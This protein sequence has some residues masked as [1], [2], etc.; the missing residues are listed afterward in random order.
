MRES[1]CQAAFVLA[2]RLIERRASSCM[3]D[4]NEISELVLVAQRLRKEAQTMREKSDK[5]IARAEELTKRMAQ[6]KGLQGLQGKSK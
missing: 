2:L 6:L 5:L 3:N 4:S 1:S